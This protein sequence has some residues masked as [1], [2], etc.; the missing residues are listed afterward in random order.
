MD[1]VDLTAHGW[2]DA[3][4][5]LSWPCSSRDYDPLGWPMSEQ[6][7]HLPRLYAE[8]ATGHD[9][10]AEA[11]DRQDAMLLALSLAWPWLMK[12]FGCLLEAQP[13]TP[14]DNR[15]VA[16]VLR[17]WV[18]SD[19]P[20]LTDELIRRINRIRQFG[21]KEKLNAWVGRQRLRFPGSEGQ[22]RIGGA[23]PSSLVGSFRDRFDLDSRPI[24]IDEAMLSLTMTLP[25]EP[26][27]RDIAALRPVLAEAV[28]LLAL[29]TP[30]LRERA[31]TVL[32]VLLSLGLNIS[33]LHMQQ[34][35][36]KLPPRG[37]QPGIYSG[38][39]KHFGR[40]IGWW[41][42]RNDIAVHRFAHGGDRTSHVDPGWDLIELPFC[43]NYI[44]HGRAEARNIRARLASGQYGAAIR[45]IPQI[46]ARGSEK[47]LALFERARATRRPARKPQRLLYIASSHH[48][49]GLPFSPA[50]KNPDLRYLEWQHWLL[51]SLRVAG[52]DVV[53]RPHPRGVNE[54]A[55]LADLGEL[56]TSKPL[57]PIST[58]ADCLV[59][60][61]PGSAWFD[62]LA[63]QTPM[64]LIDIGPRQLDARSEVLLRDRCPVI[65]TYETERNLLRADI[66]AIRA[67][68]ERA[69]SGPDAA[70]RLVEDFFT[71]ERN[72][73]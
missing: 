40:L 53:V 50:F 58:D 25:A 11:G 70:A 6:L 66:D 26:V 38:T 21:F 72:A 27:R 69:R 61:F 68:L 39:P 37:L 15:Y 12:G 5:T 4:Q 59:F 30:A 51:R 62:T 24:L 3:L 23:S 34:V 46:E 9:T 43:S 19:T 52:Y 7:S 42:R 22:W 64:V 28:E 17:Q 73:V 14:V 10:T 47:H 45:D 18:Q 8:T 2:R 49:M 29:P 57:D 44:V 63:T 55:L 60:D 31:L 48:D 71:G 54:N 20:A 33:W 56:Q 35:M 65:P 41:A 67:G 16:S 36:Q 13:S 32:Q 1:N